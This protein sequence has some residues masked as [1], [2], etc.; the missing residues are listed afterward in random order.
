MSGRDVE[1]GSSHV[2]NSSSLAVVWYDGNQQCKVFNV[3]PATPPEESVTPGETPARCSS[4]NRHSTQD[5]TTTEFV[6]L[7]ID[8]AGY[9]YSNDDVPTHT[10]HESTNSVQNLSSS[11]SSSKSHPLGGQLAV[12]GGSHQQELCEDEDESVRKVSTC[13]CPNEEGSSTPRATTTTTRETTTTTKTTTREEQTEAPTYPGPYSI[14]SRSAKHRLKSVKQSPDNNTVSQS[15]ELSTDNVVFCNVCHN[16]IT[17]T[18]TPPQGTGNQYQEYGTEVAVEVGSGSEEPPPNY[19]SLRF[20]F[21]ADEPP[22]YQDVTG[23]ALTSASIPVRV[24]NIF[25]FI[26]LDIPPDEWE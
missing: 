15:S 18:T 16:E 9:I 17:L 5:N 13:S 7:G 23:K 12:A 1:S 11:S 10:K 14:G 4:H 3:L 24:R 22:R 6:T 25:S 20:M 21:L 8:N 26:I 2:T 19:S